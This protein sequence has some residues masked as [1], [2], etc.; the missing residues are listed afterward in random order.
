MPQLTNLNTF[1]YFDDFTTDP[2]AFDYYKV[3]FKPGFPIQSR[4]LNN[5]QSILQNQIET[6]G[7]HIFKEG[8]RVIDGELSYS[9][10][11]DYVIV[12]NEYFGTR[13]T[14][15]ILDFLVGEVIKG[16]T[17]GV[18]ARIDNYITEIESDINRVTLYITY[19]NQSQTNTK[20]QAGEILEL[21][22]T[23]ELLDDEDLGEDNIL[24]QI[25]TG[26]A[27]CT[28]VSQG[29]PTGKASVVYLS[30]GY[31]YIRGF[32]VAVESQTLVIDQYKNDGD[33]KVG[34]S[35]DEFIITSNY[36][37]NLNDNARGFTNYSAPGADRFTFNVRLN[38]YNL[39]EDLDPS[40][41]VLMEIRN[42]K[43]YSY[44]KEVKYNELQRE[45]ARRTYDESGNYYVKS[46][47]VSIRETL[48]DYEGNNGVFSSNRL[49]Y[50]GNEPSES[51]GTYA[52]SPVTA[53]IFG[54]EIGTLSTTYLDF[55]KPRTTKEFISQGINYYTGPTFTLNRVYGSP[56]I[57]FASTYV[58]LRDSRVGSNQS[59]ASGNEIG[60]A[61]VYDF[62]LESGSY[63]FTYPDSNQWDIS[64]YDIQPYTTITLNSPI[65]LTTPTRI[66]GKSSGASG[67]L[68]SNVS[69][70]TSLI[71][72]NCQGNFLVG[73]S[74]LFDG[75]DNTRIATAITQY[76]ISDI[77][78]I[79]A[80]FGSGYIF[81]ADL[82][83]N[84]HIDVGQ[85]N[86]SANV[87]GISTVFT[88][89]FIFS[90]SAKSG[91]I[92][93]YTDP[94]KNAITFSKIS[95]VNVN[96]IT[97][98]GVTTVSGVCEGALPS[99]GINPSNFKILSTKLNS[100]SDN[101][102]YTK[103]PKDY[104]SSVNL[105]KS[106]LVIRKQIDVT[107]VNGSTG[108]IESDENEIFLPFD[109]ERYCLITQN[110]QTEILTEDKFVFTSGSN[111]LTINGLSGS[112]SA[113]LIA[114]LSKNTIK[115]KTKNINRVK[116]IIVN[117]SKYNGSG[118][119]GT[120]LNDGLIYG[121]YPYGTRV[122]D[123]EICLL[124][125]DV[126][127]LYKIYESNGTS[128]PE[129]PTLIFNNNISN[130]IIGERIFGTTSNSSA[131]VVEKLSTNT[132][133]I[134]YLNDEQFS[135]GEQVEFKESK[136]LS[137]VLSLS[138][139]DIDVTNK[140]TFISGQNDTILDYSKIVRKSN[141]K[142]PK[143]QLKIVFE[144]LSI[145]PN[146][147]GDIVTKNSYNQL[148]YCDIPTVNGIR[149][150]DI[151]DIRPRVSE[152]SVAENQ[153]SPFEFIGRTFSNNSS[154][155]IL[156]SD[157]SFVIDFSIYLPRTDRIYLS[158]DGIFQI[159][160]GNPSENKSSPNEILD[161][162][163]VATI[164]LPPY[165]CNLSDAEIKVREYKRYTMADI[166]KLEDRITNLEYYTTLSLLE[167]STSNTEILDSN[168]LNRFK[169]GFYVD[170]FSSTLSQKKE[171]EVKNCIDPKNSVLRP[172]H[173]TTQIDLILGTRASIGV[174]NS[175][176][177]DYRVDTNL[178]GSNV[179]R[180]GQLLTLSYD[181]VQE[182][183]QPYSTKIVNVS[184]YSSSFFT[185]TI[186]LVP[187][188][189]IWVDQV[190]LEPKSFQVDGYTESTS[191]MELTQ[192]DPQTGFGPV[193]WNS[194]ETV[195]TGTE[196]ATESDITN[197]GNYASAD[198]YEATV[199]IGT[200]SRNG[201]RNVL[202]TS[203][204]SNSLGDTVIST[205]IIPYLRSRNI[206]F[207]GKRMKPFSQVYAFF[208]GID[209]SQYIVPK[210]IEIEM[211]SGTFE[212]GETVKSSIASPNGSVIS[213]LPEISFRIAKINHK[214]GAY[215]NPTTVYNTNP[216]NIQE[217]IPSTYS[218]TSTLLNVD[219][220]SLSNQP[221][222]DY[223]GYL[224][225]NSSFILIGNSSKA[226]CK[227]KNIRLVTDQIGD[228][229]GSLWIPDP[230]ISSNPK[231]E[232]GTKTFTLTNESTNSRV[233]G[234]VTSLAEEKYYSEG[235]KQTTQENIMLIRN[236]RV[237]IQT[238]T[239]SNPTVEIGD[240]V[241]KTTEVI[242]DLPPPSSSHV[243]GS[244]GI[245]V[246]RDLPPLAAEP[247]T[248]ADPTDP[249]VARKVVLINGADPDIVGK[250]AAKK[251]NQLIKEFGVNVDKIQKGD[252]VKE[253][254]QAIMAVNKAAGTQVAAHR[255]DV[256]GSSNYVGPMGGMG[257]SNSGGS[258]SGGGAMSSGGG[259]GGG[260]TLPP[261]FSGGGG[262]SMGSGGGG[263]GGGGGG[264][265]GSG[266][267]GSG[268]GGGGMGSGGGMGKM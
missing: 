92:V 83:Q 93:S 105:S 108:E 166:R 76:K 6:F 177:N 20:F 206:E 102:L 122:Q 154:S 118:I 94:S 201:T 163:E 194:W 100:S 67:F 140:Y 268:G 174:D 197:Y 218:S 56:Q 65:T 190:K 213:I 226:Q 117:K 30:S 130:S 265:M 110:G 14:K 234:L 91:D 60:L 95:S 153:R 68:R 258:S 46:P 58:S 220:F 164:N 51:L 256:P 28:V 33:F 229:V 81:N 131:I 49:T 84:N 75:I 21:Y 4:E 119:G 214:Y 61:R 62:A 173:Y 175:E 168:G 155:N 241:Y 156:A 198:I 184:A 87:S 53:Y 47:S 239:E 224:S 36:D 26:D 219:T 169:S 266:G 132:V 44:N 143:R 57:G 32:F 63:D 73:E 120:T 179:V 172:S 157:E 243:T 261:G 211:I 210:L 245:I 7:N 18:T 1:P 121:N 262:G 225:M 64:L 103:L 158:K 17:S 8:S 89:D 162:I 242:T 135:I 40:F 208:D 27:I 244:D 247:V 79:Y 22:S 171:T 25:V 180:T 176:K 189:D 19:I 42:G 199:K 125:T 150:C 82:K 9:N 52:I 181:E 209:M 255:P 195:W 250:P 113:K 106:N 267:G 182:I 71:L 148:D 98:S 188:S 238:L 263:S 69:N 147:T 212:V 97:I 129:L 167:V 101:T 186:E 183:I 124:T 134:L 161:S 15:D 260:S 227:I 232:A 228:V 126:T 10:N 192:F 3:L 112:G 205:Q 237:E 170:D 107:I 217:T 231:F 37:E 203:I 159:S 246:E 240:I 253:L 230:N 16:R 204:D 139:G 39:Y 29:I 31:Y 80:N 254:K 222:G 38:F 90:N 187:S 144:Y 77:K 193:T 48:N 114:T 215:D 236:Q 11:V 123:E 2:Q 78:S 233:D 191:Q 257:G 138:D 86:I 160:K 13:I 115:N 252:P 259:G 223:Y 141:E 104:I 54:Y 70:S 151:I 152:Y 196:K 23:I 41:I 178:L 142:E 202:K 88:P 128:E 207:T 50:S 133:S 111:I 251:I 116:S 43:E 72:Y 74:F 145:S 264:S 127:K 66:K 24:P 248:T 45:L 34:F 35:I 200:K 59:I 149:V 185:G 137:T 136:L 165:L 85:V 249:S 146:D 99:S 109:E 5:L 235:K 12:D 216:Y 55:E 96:S 221:Q